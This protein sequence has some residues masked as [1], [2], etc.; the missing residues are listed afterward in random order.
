[1]AM[2][3]ISALIL[4]FI[5]FGLS[6]SYLEKAKTI[7]FGKQ[8]GFISKLKNE[9][10]YGDQYIGMLFG[11]PE[12]YPIYKDTAKSEIR[13]C[14]YW[15]K[16]SLFFLIVFIVFLVVGIHLGYFEASFQ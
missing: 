12:K 7:L 11:N 1:M 16:F 5:S 3:V 13:K 8:S 15:S 9:A 6:I 2:V 4:F 14:K 10:A